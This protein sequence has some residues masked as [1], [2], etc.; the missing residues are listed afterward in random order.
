MIKGKSQLGPGFLVRQVFWILCGFLSLFSTPV[1]SQSASAGADGNS[2][3]S[4]SAAITQRLST[5]EEALTNKEQQNDALN[6]QIELLE[7][8]LEKTMKMIEIQE[9]QLTRSQQQLDQML[10]TEVSPAS[11]GVQTAVPTPAASGNVTPA[12]KSPAPQQGVSAPSRAVPPPPW[13]DPGQTLGWL[14]H[15]LGVVL[16]V[17][18]T[19]GSAIVALVGGSGFELG[20]DG[21]LYIGGT[22]IL[23]LL[24]VVVIYRRRNARSQEV[25]EEPAKARARAGG[26]LFRR[27]KSDEEKKGVDPDELP[28]VSHSIDSVGAGFVTELETQRGVA[29]QSDNVDPLTEAEIYIAYGR[30]AQAE[31]VLRD[32][33]SRSPRRV[34]LKLK[35]LE[36]FENLGRG[37][38]SSALVGDIRKLVDPGSPE[39]AHLENLVA[40]INAKGGMSAQSESSGAESESGGST[41][42]LDYVASEAD[43]EEHLKRPADD[44]TIDLE[45]EFQSGREPA[46]QDGGTGGGVEERPEELPGD[47]E[48]DLE[49]DTEASP[50]DRP[51]GTKVTRD[52]KDAPPVDD[53]IDFELDFGETG[54]AN[55]ENHDSAL[56]TEV[57]NE[58]DVDD[59]IQR[60]G[61]QDDAVADELVLGD[62]SDPQTRLDLAEAFLGMGDDEAAREILEELKSSSDVAIAKRV[63]ELLERV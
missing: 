11:A 28:P 44:M 13:V 41:G 29:V 63:A 40:K 38:E 5:T 15:Y 27:E 48:F 34:E 26:S 25:V 52:K 22:V 4:G 37:G 33:I 47:L 16:G 49:V 55:Q 30:T 36:L 51:A 32:A 46:A 58:S 53:G 59:L 31:Q 6:K 43:A 21:G 35:L 62:D 1:F 3:E 23:V 61:E 14:S 7:R 8:Q 54:V 45:S 42:D 39:E 9:S 56:T 17:L 24:L 10:G 19:A 18:S 20:T 2:S 12:A 60:P 50:S 57:G